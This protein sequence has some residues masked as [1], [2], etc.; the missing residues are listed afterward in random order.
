MVEPGNQRRAVC[1]A[2]TADQNIDVAVRV[3]VGRLDREGEEIG[4]ARA[5]R[6]AEAAVTVVE[7]EPRSVCLRAQEV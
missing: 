7:K 2:T 1:V 6:L 3:I 4:Q 5:L